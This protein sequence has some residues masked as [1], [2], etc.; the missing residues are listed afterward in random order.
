M[1][2]DRKSG[3]PEAK[4]LRKPTSGSVLEFLKN[5]IVLF[6]APK[7]MRTDPGSPFRSEKIRQFS[8]ERCIEHFERPIGDHQGNGKTESCIRTKTECLRT[9]KCFILQKDQTGLS[10]VFFALRTGK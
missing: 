10:E 4:F 3:C 7:R 8:R 5:Y 2:F 9:N 1:S 6:G